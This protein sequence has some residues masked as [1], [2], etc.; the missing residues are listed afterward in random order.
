MLSI[1]QGVE[2]SQDP[3]FL[4]SQRAF[5]QHRIAEIKGIL[6]ERR[7]K[8]PV[9]AIT[10]PTPRVDPY[11]KPGQPSAA[12]ASSSRQPIP[13]ISC[14]DDVEDDEVIVGV[15][16]D[17]GVWLDDGA[18]LLID[19][20]KTPSPPAH[21]AVDDA[22]PDPGPSSRP[23]PPPNH[24]QSR[25]RAQSHPETLPLP[26]P[27]RQPYVPAPHIVNP[28]LTTTANAARERQTVN[29]MPTH[30]PAT[31]QRAHTSTNAGAIQ[32]SKAAAPSVQ[33]FPWSA[34]VRKALH[35]TFQLTEFR[36]NQLEAINATLGGYDVFCLMPTGG[37]KS[38]CYQLPAIVESG[39]TRGVTI[40][41]SP[42]ISLIHD[43]VN[44]LLKLGIP[45]LRITGDMP[46]KD[47]ERALAEIFARDATPQAMLPAL[48]YLTPEFVN[49][50]RVAADIFA[51][52]SRRNRLARFVVDEAHCVSQWGHDFRPDYKEMGQLKRDYPHV[53][54]MAMTA[55][56]TSRVRHDVMAHLNVDKARL[57]QFQQSFNRPNLHY[58]VREKRTK[59]GV[60]EDMARFISGQ[61]RD[62]CGIVY[63]LSR[64]ACEEVAGDLG[65]AHN[66]KAQHYH[67]GMS[68]RDRIR[69]Q[70]GWQ[71]NEF[72]VIVAT[73]A[74]GMGIDKGDVRFVVHHTMPTS[75]EGYYQETGRAG[76][77]GRSAD[78]VLF[79]NYKDSNG[80]RMMI[81]E[82]E[83]TRHQKEQQHD[84][85]RQVVM[86]AMNTLD[87]RRAQ[88]LQYFGEVFA[89]EACHH[90]CDNCCR[91]QRESNDENRMTNTDVTGIASQALQLVEGIVRAGDSVTML[92]CVDVLRGS[93]KTAIKAKGHDELAGFASAKH[94]A[95]GDV[96]RL[97]QR[98]VVEG[99]L[100]ERSEQNGMGFTNAYMTFNRREADAIQSGA[101]TISM[102]MKK[103]GAT[104]QQESSTNTRTISRKRSGYQARAR[105]LE[106]S[107]EDFEYAPDELDV[108]NFDM[109]A[110]PNASTTPSITTRRQ[111]QQQQIQ[112]RQQAIDLG[113]DFDIND[114]PEVVDLD[115]DDDNGGHSMEDDGAANT[116]AAAERGEGDL[117]AQCYRELKA[118]RNQVS[119]DQRM[120]PREVYTDETLQEMSLLL[121]VCEY[122]NIELNLKDLWADHHKSA[123]DKF[124]QIEGVDRAKWASFGR[125]FLD[126]C[127]KYTGRQASM[128]GR[129]SKTMSSTAQQ[130]PAAAPQP[131]QQGHPEPRQTGP[132]Q[133]PPQQSE[134]SKPA[135]R[136]LLRELDLQQFAFQTPSAQDSSFGSSED[137]TPAESASNVKKEKTPVKQPQQ[138]QS[139]PKSN[140]RTTAATMAARKAMAPPAPRPSF[141]SGGGGGGGI[142]AMPTM[143]GGSTS[144]SNQAP[145]AAGQAGRGGSRGTGR[146]GRGRGRG[147]GGRGAARA[148][149]GRDR[150]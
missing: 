31:T 73:I 32:K 129:N 47:R 101:R 108:A 134:T 105:P 2:S 48:V 127:T 138:Q 75:L 18:A 88:I 55:T 84:N 133:R 21:P 137:S 64:R 80:I 136:S 116:S 142:R 42:L 99:A 62:E 119:R 50:S 70:Q 22:H 93:T 24:S 49:K 85:L 14:D 91:M 72:K 92:H 3:A 149:T 120:A 36:P 113:S 94:L 117:F 107:E 144:S 25:I 41:I 13:H 44:H 103:Q 97:F 54:L 15:D 139:L 82:G 145:G 43:Q 90:T 147:G 78:C 141:S 130:R 7:R 51:H 89:A 122:E 140:G 146:G 124:L 61:H 95:R 30:N 45:A 60:L 56:A 148:S 26:P 17:E 52:L 57:K 33:D 74:F 12:S 38:L 27:S 86:Y 46:A 77:D 8:G 87:C 1:A 58:Y 112:Q 53:P 76:R 34:D 23:R 83:G 118:H 102:P 39:R 66:I 67:A 110:E 16:D 4:E 111:Q 71:D 150:F 28:S 69:V 98:L 131:L 135:P 65:R 132:Q 19:G 126:I 29:A 68:K 115:E 123:V 40:V 114:F 63:C 9:G 104:T 125:G 106:V 6:E 100:G 128:Y 109:D 81:D 121:P 10:T 96:E 11:P 59:A 37:G 143:S 5:L 20:I 35:N 79:F